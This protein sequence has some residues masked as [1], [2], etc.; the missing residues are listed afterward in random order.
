MGARGA[1]GRRDRRLLRQGRT[2]PGKARPSRAGL[3]GLVVLSVRLGATERGEAPLRAM[4]GGVPRLWDPPFAFRTGRAFP[5][6]E[7]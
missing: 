2:G 3:G 7:A 4:A 6:C 5:L 1:A